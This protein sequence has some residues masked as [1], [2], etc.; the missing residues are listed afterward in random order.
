MVRHKPAAPK[1]KPKCPV[2]TV[3]CLS[4][5]NRT[6]I[7]SWFPFCFPSASSLKDDVLSSPALISARAKHN[8]AGHNTNIANPK[9]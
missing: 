7:N 6:L 3:A 4:A 5:R 8:K 9:V 2:S 1:S